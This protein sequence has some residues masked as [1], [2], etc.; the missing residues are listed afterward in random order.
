MCK[1]SELFY[2]HIFILAR[3]KFHLKSG[4]SPLKIA[5]MISIKRLSFCL[6]LILGLTNC[7]HKIRRTG[8]ELDKTEQ[9]TCPVAIVKS[10]TITDSI[11]KVG[12]IKLG[13]TGFSVACSEKHALEILTK[14]ACSLQAD[15][16]FITSETRPDLLSSCYRCEASFYKRTTQTAPLISDAEFDNKVVT[17][18]VSEDRARNTGIVIFSIFIGVAIGLLLVL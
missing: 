5:N 11:Q 14:E 18:R 10:L 16:V 9:Q 8:Y 15:I 13:E 2:A 7:S 4:S 12:S 17:Q 3:R 1:T 6:I